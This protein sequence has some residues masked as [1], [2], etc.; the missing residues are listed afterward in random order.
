MKHL[1]SSD[2]SP[3]FVKSSTD[4]QPKHELEPPLKLKH[5][6]ASFAYKKANWNE[7]TQFII[8][9][10]FDPYC[11]SNVDLMVDLWYE[12][13]H[14]ILQ[15]F[16]TIKTKH[17]VTLAPWVGKESS[18]LIKTQHFAEELQNERQTC[19]ESQSWRNSGKAD[20]ITTK[21]PV[22]PRNKTDPRRQVLGLTE[23]P[24]INFK[25]KRYTIRNPL[26]TERLE[27]WLW[28]S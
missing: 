28:K 15:D 12:W 19:S 5:D 18:R 8:D 11:K 23:V 4:L 6:F 13:L 26:R 27:R 22:E 25:G 17:R 7:I 20:I 3:F 9:H 24:K 14:V 2:H 16:L 10:P 1:F 21:R